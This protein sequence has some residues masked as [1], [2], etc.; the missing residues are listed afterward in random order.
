MIFPFGGGIV[1]HL[2]KRGCTL[3]EFGV[4]V[5]NSEEILASF[6]VEAEHGLPFKNKFINL[7][8]QKF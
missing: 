6:S 8:K 1:F 3:V 7:P 2:G 4:A 5:G